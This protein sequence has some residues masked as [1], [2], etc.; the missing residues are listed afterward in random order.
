MKT[1]SIF[2]ALSKTRYLAVLML[3]MFACT[4]AWGVESSEVAGSSSSSVS[5]GDMFVIKATYSGNT[6]YLT[7]TVS[8]N[9]GITTTSLSDAA[10]FTAHGT[11]T[12]FYLTCS[13]GTLVPSTG[14]YQA[15]NNGT[16]NNLKLSSSKITNLSNDSHYLN[17]NHNSGNGGGRWYSTTQSAIFY[18]YKVT[19][20]PKTVTYNA[21]SGTCKA[22]DT[23]ASGGAGITLP[24]AVPSARCAA[25]GWVFAGWKKTSALSATTTPPAL[26]PGGG[27]YYPGTSE[28]LYAVY[29][30]GEY[31]MIDFESASSAY[32]DWTFTK[33]TS[34]ESGAVS[35]YNGSKYGTTDAASTAA[36]KTNK[37]IA[38]PTLIRFY[39][40]KTTDNNTACSWKVQTST[41]GSTWTDRKEQSAVSMSKGV[42]VEVTQ[43]LSAYSNV[44]VRIYYG[45]NTAVRAIDDVMLSCGATFN[46][47][48]DCT[49]DNFVD[50][51]HGNETIR[52]QGT[53]S[54]PAA[55][56]DA[57]KGDDY[58]AEKHY[59]FVGW[60][61]EAYVN[62]DGT[63]KSGYESYL[64]AP[65][66]S[67][68]TANNTTYYA[69]WAE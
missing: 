51:M 60:L 57:D 50:N 56:S 15:Y 66:H 43:D 14:N 11:T 33:M 19:L 18:L 63:L 47:N 65:G 48:P 32:T 29:A 49:F 34:N 26:I 54:M 7:T 23:E 42:W 5:N 9:W 17:Y 46:S 64:H 6:Y 39:V 62:A 58:C 31:Y 28:T 25:E 69:I 21:G 8:G 27:K 44:Y 13:A 55:L 45:S 53:Y 41:D 38:S 2:K 16:T 1:N 3:V 59:H 61:S 4:Y 52:K 67:G 30:Q 20:T 68:H 37:M 10:V 35:P 40:T 12:G 24:S 22:S 36:I